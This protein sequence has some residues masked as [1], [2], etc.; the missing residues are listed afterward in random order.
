MLYADGTSMAYVGNDLQELTNH[1]NHKLSV[2]SEGCKFNELALNPEKS[3]FIF[4]NK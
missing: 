4:F 1:V 2:V 3:E